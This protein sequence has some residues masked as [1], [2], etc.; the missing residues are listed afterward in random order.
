MWELA[1]RQAKERA[2]AKEIEERR[3]QEDEKRVRD[4]GIAT[5][6]NFDHVQFCA[7]IH[8]FMCDMREMR[9]ELNSLRERYDEELPCIREQYDVIDAKVKSC[10]ITLSNL[11]GA[12]DGQQ[13]DV[14]RRC[15]SPY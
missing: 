5:L 15:E 7:C 12:M 10:T 4:E 3:V 13:C 9:T 2:D 6:A 14:R 8:D 1:A 11:R